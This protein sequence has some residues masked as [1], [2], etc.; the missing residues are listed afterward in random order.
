MNTENAE[1]QPQVKSKRGRKPKNATLQSNPASTNNSPTNKTSQINDMF[2][3][4]N[5]PAINNT[6]NV[7]LNVSEN[8]DNEQ[9]NS[10][11]MEETLGLTN[12]NEEEPTNQK[13]P[14]KKR[15]RKPKGGKI[16]SLSV[17]SNDQ[18]KQKPNVILH[19]KCSLNDL[20]SNNGFGENID[21]F[22]FIASNQCNYELINNDQLSMSTINNITSNVKFTD[23]INNINEDEDVDESNLDDV[24]VKE[25]WKKLKL[26]EH[27]LHINDVNDKRSACFFDT[28]DFDTPP[29]YIPKHSI[30]GSYHVYGCFCSPECAVAHLMNEN[31][32]TS[33]KFERYHL[34]NHIYGSIYKYKKNIKPAPNPYYML[35]KFYGNLSIR[36]YRSLLKYERLF[37]IVD[38]PLTRIMPE[39]HEDN[40][41]FILNSK[42]IPSNNFQVKKKFQKKSSSKSNILNEQFGIV[43]Q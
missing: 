2:H 40:D 28:C 36:D 21:S 25:I 16:V 15:G 29:V 18:Q 12:T 1:V 33:T 41:D 24:D 26:L 7:I 20:K 23:N 13:Q 31:I 30:N 10:D 8:N 43:S 35:D 5:T 27:K 14:Q 4:N 42:I 22:N 9:H 34:I 17:L 3:N 37:L 32:D 6:N 11:F 39:L 38:K 19:L